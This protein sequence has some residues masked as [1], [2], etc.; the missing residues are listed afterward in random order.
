MIAVR[1]EEDR[2]RNMHVDT[3][4]GHKSVHVLWYAGYYLSPPFVVDHGHNFG[5]RFCMQQHEMHKPQGEMKANVFACVILYF[6]PFSS[7]AQMRKKGRLILCIPFCS[8][9]HIPSDV[10]LL[11]FFAR[12]CRV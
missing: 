7:T 10:L 2:T 6:P 9:S 5:L 11:S 1:G 4:A 8:L 12:Q 3:N